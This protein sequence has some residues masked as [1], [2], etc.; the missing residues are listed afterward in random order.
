MRPTTI[1]AVGLVASGATAVFVYRAV[2]KR[3][4]V[5]T[6][7]VADAAHLKVRPVVVAG[8]D[9]PLGTTL[10]A[11]HVKTVPWPTHALPESAFETPQAVVGRVT[12][13]RLVAN[14]PLT[15][16]KLAPVDARGLLPLVIDRGMRGVT[17]RVDEVAGV[18]GFIVPGSRVDVLVTAEVESQATQAFAA[19]SGGV[20]VADVKERQTRTL[21]QNVT[22]LALGQTVEST[23]T[24]PKDGRSLTTATLLV[25]PDQ[26]ELLALGAAEGTLQLALRNFEDNGIAYL[27][28][29]K[30][31][32]L[33]ALDTLA[34][35]VVAQ[36]KVEMILGAQRLALLF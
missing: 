5:R 6:E 35:P 8:K 9:L 22:V 34:E 26:G 20:Q 15:N 27:E 31:Q 33:F 2:Q 19:A 4:I 16:I 36:N 23:A 1:L 21:L 7:P 25:T 18:G 24:E 3:V 13:A 17:V 29:K 10:A 11:E 12:L 32:D 30:A 14:E 28:G